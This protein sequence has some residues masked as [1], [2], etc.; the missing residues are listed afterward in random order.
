MSHRLIF[1]CLSGLIAGSVLISAA[2]ALASE[3]TV[4][5]FLTLG[6]N[7]PRNRA[8][9]LLKPETRRLIGEV[10]TSVRQIKAEQSAAEASG[11][12]PAHCIP[13]SGTGITPEALVQ[14]FETMPNARRQIT[15]TSAIRNWMVERYPCNG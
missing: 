15:V 9:A 8:A 14:R 12:R 13:S 1:L 2:P 11:R 7:V 6:Q 10:T 3:M 5:Q 4:Q